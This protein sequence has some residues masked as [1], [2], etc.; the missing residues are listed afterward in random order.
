MAGVSLIWWQLAGTG[1]GVLG[2]LAVRA[3]DEWRWWQIARYYLPQPVVN[4]APPTLTELNDATW[5][6]KP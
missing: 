1:V 3:Y 5:I 4:T 2:V 6:E